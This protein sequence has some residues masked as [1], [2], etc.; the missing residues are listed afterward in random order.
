MAAEYLA[1][2]AQVVALNTP[3]NMVAS[4]PCTKGYVIHDNG[5]GIFILRGITEQCY[6]TYQ[7]TFN[8][9]IGI[10]DGEPTP[11]AI[12]LSV[13]G[14]PRLT[15]RAI[16]V[17]TGTIADGD[18]GNVTSTAI[19]R[20]PRGCCFTISV[21]YVNGNTADPT[22]VPAPTISVIDSNLVIERIA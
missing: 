7:V 17:P 18:Y 6:A 11:I 9:N 2:A 10:P 13:N 8:A 3:V 4:I 19:I 15:S 21:D 1:Q 22:A 5:T 20:V 12:A 16:Y 14:E